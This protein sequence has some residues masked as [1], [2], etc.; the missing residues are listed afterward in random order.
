M[1]NPITRNHTYVLQNAN[2]TTE[3]SRYTTTKLII[4]VK[5]ERYE[6]KVLLYYPFPLVCGFLMDNTG[7]LVLTTQKLQ[8]VAGGI[9]FCCGYWIMQKIT[10]YLEN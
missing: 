5:Y 4:I 9:Y 8:K 6:A 7:S 10:R 3:A 2:T 1:S